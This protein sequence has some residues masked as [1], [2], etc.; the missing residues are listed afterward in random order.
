[1]ALTDVPAQR[2][3]SDCA[4]IASRERRGRHW[5]AV[6]AGPHLRGTD[7]RK[8][9]TRL[10]VFWWNE[11]KPLQGQGG[12][13]TAR[14]APGR[15]LP[16]DSRI[17]ERP[18]CARA[19]Q[20]R[21]AHDGRGLFLNGRPLTGRRSVES[22]GRYG[23]SAVPTTPRR[24]IGPSRSVTPRGEGLQAEQGGHP[25]LARVDGGPNRVPHQSSPFGR[26]RY[27]WCADPPSRGD[28]APFDC[29]ALPGHGTSPKCVGS[30]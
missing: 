18:P 1:V 16:S 20:G 11:R 9:T 27:P 26:C 23:G 21:C 15:D 19:L 14:K 17:P 4:R 25:L 3:L 5:C 12:R 24:V 30:R 7:S 8:G 6:D 10:T 29:S 13:H 28:E 2:P 22:A